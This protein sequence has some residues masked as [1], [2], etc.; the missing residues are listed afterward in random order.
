MAIKR[1]PE[2]DIY[3]TQEEDMKPKTAWAWLS[4]PGHNLI[5]YGNGGQFQYP[6]F[7]TRREARDW[8]TKTCG[9]PGQLTRLVK[10]TIRA[11]STTTK[12]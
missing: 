4:K 1:I 8:A 7:Y 11:A 5:S 3:L 10:V 9:S 2:G 12:R 6:I